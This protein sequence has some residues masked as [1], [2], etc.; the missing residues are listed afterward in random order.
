MSRQPLPAFMDTDRWAADVMKSVLLVECRD[1][2]AA[3]LIND[4][5]ELG[6]NVH[7]VSNGAEA[8]KALRCE[9][10]SLVVVH[11]FV[12]D[13]SGWLIA[14]K[15]RLLLRDTEIWL[16][17]PS[18]APYGVGLAHLVGVDRVIFYGGD[19]WMLSESVTRMAEHA[20]QREIL[21]RKG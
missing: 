19:L 16:Y 8:S 10:F 14:A 4:L 17:T 15:A 21:S 6:A 11:V 3:R 1:E 7:R 2:F 13:E 20:W 5:Q 12:P 9:T 18:I